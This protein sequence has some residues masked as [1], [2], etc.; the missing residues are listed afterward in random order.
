MTHRYN[1]NTIGN[2]RHMFIKTP[3]MSSSVD[4]A[5]PIWEMI[6]I[7]ESEYNIRFNMQITTPVETEKEVVEVMEEN[8]PTETI[9]E[10]KKI[11]AEEVEESMNEKIEEVKQIVEEVKEIV[12]EV[13]D[14]DE[15]DLSSIEPTETIEMS[16]EFLKTDLSQM[17]FEAKPS[18]IRKTRS[19]RFKQAEW[20]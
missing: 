4:L 14:D 9:E 11:E 5:V 19:L 15:V 17:S 7:S 10:T 16:N 3:S 13:K 1:G 12:E 18:L 6:G 2:H 8:K 20:T